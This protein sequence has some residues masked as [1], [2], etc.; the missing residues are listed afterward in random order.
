MSCPAQ[1]TSHQTHPF[2]ETLDGAT[3]SVSW[4]WHAHRLPPVW[5]LC[6]IVAEMS[7]CVRDQMTPKPEHTDN[8]ALYGASLLSPGL[9]WT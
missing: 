2:R 3:T 6:T 5:L 4:G 7:G 8:L 9:E 1:V